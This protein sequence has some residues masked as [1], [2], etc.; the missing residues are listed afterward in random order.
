MW[1]PVACEAK[2]KRLVAV[3]LGVVS[4]PPTKT[5]YKY[6]CAHYTM[7]LISTQ[8]SYKT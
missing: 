7:E 3:G 8:S 4:P 5:T 1:K 2:E 6:L